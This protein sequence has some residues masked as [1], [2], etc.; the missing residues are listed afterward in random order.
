MCK[1]IYKGYYAC[2][3]RSLHKFKPCSS[4]NCRDLPFTMEKAEASARIAGPGGASSPVFGT[5]PS[6]SIYEYAPK[7]GGVLT[8]SNLLMLYCYCFLFERGKLEGWVHGS[9]RLLKTSPIS[10]GPEKRTVFTTEALGFWSSTGAEP[11]INIFLF[12]LPGL[13]S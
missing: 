9:G 12:C 1:K 10:D 11:K 2:G 13:L 6:R 5:L 3:H 7:K 4:T 8:V